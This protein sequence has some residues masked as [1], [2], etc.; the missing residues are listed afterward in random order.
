MF[1]LVDDA[2]GLKELMDCLDVA[3]K[4]SRHH[5]AAIRAKGICRESEEGDILVMLGASRQRMEKPVERRV[6]EATM[7]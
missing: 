6:V 3:L 7:Q 4:S 5:H 2:L 1:V